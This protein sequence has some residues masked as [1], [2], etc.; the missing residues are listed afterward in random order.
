MVIKIRKM[1]VIIIIGKN[2]SGDKFFKVELLLFKVWL[3]VWVM[4]NFFEVLFGLVCMVIMGIVFF[5]RVGK[6]WRNLN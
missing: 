5:G 3:G 1:I 6:V 2:N 4:I